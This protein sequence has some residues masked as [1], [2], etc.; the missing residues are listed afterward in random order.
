VARI[1]AF[2]SG[3]QNPLLRLRAV[4]DNTAMQTEPPKSEPPKRKRRGF[5]FRLRTL[6]VVTTIV[7]AWAWFSQIIP[8]LDTVGRVGRMTV[9]EPNI[10]WFLA[11]GLA[12][13]AIWSA[14]RRDRL[15]QQNS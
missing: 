8:L 4:P 9:Y 14:L 12:G 6:F 1:A 5:Q 13:V 3:G 11:T 2:A 10:E 15:R 7:A